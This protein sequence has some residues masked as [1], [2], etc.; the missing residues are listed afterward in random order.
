MHSHR[1]TFALSWPSLPFYSLSK[2][3][4]ENYLYLGQ[5]NDGFFENNGF[6]MMVESYFKRELGF[7]SHLINYLYISLMIECIT[8]VSYS[9]LV[10]GKPHGFVK[11]S[12][13]LR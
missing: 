6:K 7:P 2:L 4:Q 8:S 5:Q 13:G 10:N 3:T 11:P 9:L 1:F 12:R